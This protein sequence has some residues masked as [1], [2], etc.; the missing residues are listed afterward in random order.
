MHVACDLCHAAKQKCSG[1]RPTC[2]RCAAGGW[3]CVYAPRQRR[4]TVPKEQR[5]SSVTHDQPRSQVMSALNSQPQ[6]SS[7]Q[8]QQMAK[9]RKLSQRDSAF[10]DGIDM[11]RAMGMAVDMGLAA[12]EEGEELISMTDDQMVKLFSKDMGMCWLTISWKLSL[13]TATWRIYPSQHSSI[14]SRTT[15]SNRMIIT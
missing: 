15:L 11:Q 9:K 12:E 2:T 8:Q 6:M 3:H 10:G 7:L 4:R 13:S 1:D 14:I 5:G